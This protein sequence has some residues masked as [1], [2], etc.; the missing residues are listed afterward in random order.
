MEKMTQTRY[1]WEFKGPMRWERMRAAVYKTAS[2]FANSEL[3]KLFESF[4]PTLEATEHGPFQ[5]TDFLNTLGKFPLSIAILENYYAQETHDWKPFDPCTNHRIECARKDGQ[6]MLNITIRGH[7][8][9]LI[10]DSGG[11][12]SGSPPVLVRPRRYE[13]ILTSIEEHFSRSR[14]TLLMEELEK[15]VE[16][17][18]VFL[19]RLMHRPTHTMERYIPQEHHARVLELLDNANNI[20]PQVQTRIQTLLPTLLNKYKECEVRQSSTE[21]LH[22]KRLTKSVQKTLMTGLPGSKWNF[23]GFFRIDSLYSRQ[24]MLDH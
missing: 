14:M 23:D 7:D 19:L 2:D 21:T 20:G 22:P 13:L 8:Y 10:F 9:V 5:F 4:D 3:V 12:A 16:E 1:H 11:G 6:S 24:T 17:P 18:R 15:H